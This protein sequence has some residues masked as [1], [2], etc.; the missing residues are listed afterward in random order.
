MGRKKAALFKVEV[1]CTPFISA[2]SF[3]NYG[4]NCAKDIAGCAFQ[5][6][7]YHPSRGCVC[8]AGWEG[9]NCDVDVNECLDANICEDVNAVCYNR[10][11]FYECLCRD[12]FQKQ[13]DGKCAGR[14]TP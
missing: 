7:S 5:Y 9:P 6:A 14:S 1:K 8:N 10:R 4:L 11:G 12:G 2:C 3:P 13:A